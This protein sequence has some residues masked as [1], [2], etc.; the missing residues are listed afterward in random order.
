[1]PDDIEKAVVDEDFMRILDEGIK[2]NRKALNR[3]V[4][5]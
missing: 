5:K 1:M 2:K 4:K 3:L